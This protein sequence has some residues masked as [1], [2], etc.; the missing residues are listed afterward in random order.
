MNEA[1]K[2]I[3]FQLGTSAWRQE[4]CIFAV[5]TPVDDVWS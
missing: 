1:S 3:G 2:A 4:W 5:N